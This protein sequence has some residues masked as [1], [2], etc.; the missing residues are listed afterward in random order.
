MQRNYIKA[1]LSLPQICVLAGFL[2]RLS[3][4]MS[5]PDSDGLHKFLLNLVA[6][7]LQANPNNFSRILLHKA[8]NYLTSCDVCKTFVCARTELVRLDEVICIL[9]NDEINQLSNVCLL[10]SHTLSASLVTYS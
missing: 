6:S 3:P 8:L 4:L 5:S 1:G 9:M 2:Q 10:Y 7:A